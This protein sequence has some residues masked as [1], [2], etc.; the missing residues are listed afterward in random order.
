MRK[1]PCGNRL[2]NGEYGDCSDCLLERSRNRL[3]RA[4][5]LTAEGRKYDY[6][7]AGSTLELARAQA[8]AVLPHHRPHMASLHAVEYMGPIKANDRSARL[9]T[10]LTP[11]PERA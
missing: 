10:R 1:C 9:T 11:R 4:T 7:F 5:Y 2:Y 6:T 3:Y 8:I